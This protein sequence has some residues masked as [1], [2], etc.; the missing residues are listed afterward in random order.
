MLLLILSSS[1]IELNFNKIFWS[2][3]LID[4]AN[5]SNSFNSNSLLQCDPDTEFTCDDGTCI[6][7][8]QRCDEISNCLDDSDEDRCEIVII[9]GTS[10]RKQHPPLNVQGRN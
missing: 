3:P 6:S 5:V 8:D 7:I 1:A 4:E 9:D 2:L 10:Y